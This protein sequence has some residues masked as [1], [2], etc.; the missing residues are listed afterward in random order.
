MNYLLTIL[1]TPIHD[2]DFIISFSRFMEPITKTDGRYAQYHN[3]LLLYHFDTELEL[4]DVRDH[5]VELEKSFGLH[6]ILSEVNSTTTFCMWVEEVDGILNL[7]PDIPTKDL[8]FVIEPQTEEMD[9]AEYDDDDKDDEVVQKLIQKYKLKDIEP[10]LDEILE[11]IYEKGTSSLS[12]QE[13]AV[14]NQFK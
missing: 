13:Q 5:L 2:Y 1:N 3:G 7:G 8:P 9:M 10:T 11:K 4:I 6:F 14:L 12:I